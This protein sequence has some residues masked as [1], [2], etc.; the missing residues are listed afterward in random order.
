MITKT[1]WQYS[2]PLSPDTM[3]FLCGI[4]ADYAKVK[5]YVYGRYSGIRY[6]NRLVP[7]YDVLS[8]MR[9]CGMRQELNLP[10]VYYELAINEAII[11]IKTMWNNL[12]NKVRELIGRNEN[13]SDGDRQY[14]RTVLKINIVFAAVLNRESYD[15]P[16]TVADLTVDITRLNNLICR[17]Q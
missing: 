8:E 9:Y 15:I 13:L 16:R 1:V 12:K 6:V 11:D 7:V 14:I 4:A 2:E 10:V 5:A 17:H 3:E